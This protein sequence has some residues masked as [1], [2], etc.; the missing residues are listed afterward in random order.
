MPKILPHHI[1]PK[2]KKELLKDFYDFIYS[3]D[4]KETEDFFHNF[5][6]PSEKIILARRLRVA[7]MLLQ[8]YSQ[9]QVRKKLGVGVSTI[10]FVQNWIRDELAERKSKQSLP[11]QNH[12]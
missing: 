3:L 10:Q 5:L 12:K 4:R 1:P 2:T 6:T 11:L 8:G 7:K 9:V